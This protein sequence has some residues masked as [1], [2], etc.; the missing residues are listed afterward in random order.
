MRD[1]EKVVGERLALL[2][3]EERERREVIAELAGHLEE[4]YEASRQRGAS[5]DEAIRCAL[6]QVENWDKLQRQIHAARRKENAMNARTSRLWLPSLLT[7]AASFIT[8][9]AFGFLGLPPGPLGSRP[10]HEEWSSHLIGGILGGRHVV[11]EYTVWLM[12]LPLIGAL[13]AGLSRRAGG[14]RREII[15]SGVFPAVAWLTIAIIVLSYAASLGYRDGIS[16]IHT[17]GVLEV[18][19]A[20]VGPVGLI[21]VLVLIPGGCLLLGVLVY[22]AVAKRWT[23]SVA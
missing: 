16:H 17:A 23:K 14:T 3:L 15:V 10:H 18:V 9:V 21:T 20:P 13:G 4:I 22:Y 6:L 8:L 11:N 1:W 5:D 2:S 12:A 19:T 7:L